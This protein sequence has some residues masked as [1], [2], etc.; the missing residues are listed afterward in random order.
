MGIEE[1]I[2]TV[3][4]VRKSSADSADIEREIRKAATAAIRSAANDEREKCA[5]I[6][7]SCAEPAGTLVPGLVIEADPTKKQ[8]CLQ[9]ADRI[10]QRG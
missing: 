2:S 8:I 1:F 3:L 6:A 7:E 5:L 9:I 4:E 10:R